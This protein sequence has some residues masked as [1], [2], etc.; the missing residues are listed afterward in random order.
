[1]PTQ[2]QRLVVLM[3]EN[4][5]FDHMLGF[6]KQTNPNI[7]GLTGVEWNYP[8]DELAPNVVVSNDAGDVQDL[9][10]RIVDELLVAVIDAGNRVTSRH[11]S[12]V[13]L[14]AG[15]NSNR[16]ESATAIADEVAIVDDEPA[17]KNPYTKVLFAGRR[18][19]K[20]QFEVRHL[21]SRAL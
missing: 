2:I 6:L 10:R 4:R 18:W 17:S 12:R 7:N 16:I 14:N 19:R 9:D 5:S 8:A 15:C 3:L 11:A 13:L 21:G 20:T 1:M